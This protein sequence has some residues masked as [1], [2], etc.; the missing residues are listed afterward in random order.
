[1]SRLIYSKPDHSQ[2][3]A[4]RSTDR[5]KLIITTFREQTAALLIRNNR[6]IL[7]AVFSEQTSQVGAIYLGKV[8]KLLKNIDACFVEIADK[9]LVYLPLSQCKAPFLVNRSFDGRILEGDE[10]PVQIE[11]DSLKTKQAAVT[12]KITLQGRYAVFSTGSCKTGISSKLSQEQKSSIYALL[13]DKG[14]IDEKLNWKQSPQMPAYG[15]VIRTEAAAALHTESLLSELVVLEERFQQIFAKARYRTCFTCL[16]A[17]KEPWEAC[18]GQ[19]PIREYA[20]VVTDQPKLYEEMQNYFQECGIPVRLYEDAAYSLRSLYSLD[21]KLEDALSRRIWLKSGGYLVIDVTEALT[22]F[23]V[24]SGKYDA[25]K[26]SDEAFYQINL[27][28]ARE[29]ALQIRLRNLSGI[30]LIDFINMSDTDRQEHLLAYMREL[31]KNDP[32]H[33]TVV[34]I[35]PLGLMEI[36]RKKVNKPLAEQFGRGSKQQS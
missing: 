25:R 1:M 27:E 23:D 6:L 18:V 11:R 5:G 10:L 22:V 4:L 34:D 33:T 15:V 8:K 14:L 17:P 13:L 16:S 24:N 7:A 3:N 30:L 9:E 21:T 31:V 32:V 29:I 2:Y 28:A 36:T 20:E 35:T 12:A 19:I 26:P